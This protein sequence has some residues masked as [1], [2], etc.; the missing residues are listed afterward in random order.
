MNPFTDFGFKRLFGRE[1]CKDLLIEFL[2]DLLDGERQVKDLKFID[3][4]ILPEEEDGR[5]VIFDILCR[6]EN[7][8]LFIVEMQN[9]AQRYFLDRAVYYLCRMIDGQGR[10]GKD[11]KYDF[12][13]VY[14]IY[15]LNFSVEQLEK[16]RTDVFL[17]DIATG[18]PIS[19]KLHQIYLCLP[20]FTLEADE[21]ET[22][23]KKWIYILKNMETL[24]R[25]PFKA[26]KAVFNKLLEVADVS[27]LSHQDRMR[28]EEVLKNYRDY[29]NCL[30]Y[31][32]ER[33]IEKGREEGVQE[34]ILKT[35]RALKLKGVNPQFI[36]EVTNLPLEE[37]EKL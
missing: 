37:I 36:A 27:S 19:Y 34:G 13:P 10:K 20:Y 9:V 5:M 25:M 26:Q 24:K 3:K 35:A 28:Y 7:G 2:N 16:F 15:F 33:G 12:C 11:W 23:F 17:C 22:D 21:C 29:N 31:A 6:E 4:E 1:V 14:G 8:S 30:D 32:E 18:K